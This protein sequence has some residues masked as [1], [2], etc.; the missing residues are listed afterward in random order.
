MTS[1]TTPSPG[2]NL[3]LDLLRLVAVLLVLGNHMTLAGSGGNPLLDA[4]SRVGWVGVD[5]FF[6]LSG[7][8]VS[9]LLFQEHLRTG[10]VAIGRFLVRRGLKIYPPFWVLIAY[11]VVTAWAH[12]LPQAWQAVASELFFVQNYGWHL[13][14]HTWSL[15]VEEHFYLLL[16]ALVWLLV[17]YRRDPFRLLP[18]ICGVALGAGLGLRILN[19]YQNP[20]YSYGAY[21]A[22][23]QLRIDSLFLGMLLSH[24]FY[25]RDLPARIRSFAPGWRIAFGATLLLVPAYFYN[26]ESHLWV[27]VIGYNLLDLGAALL[28]LGVVGL[29]SSR[30][31]ILCS[32][33]T[34][35]SAS[36]SIY[37]WHMP[38]EFWARRLWPVH[39]QGQ[40]HYF[41]YFV[42]FIGGSLLFGCV[43]S[44]LIEIPVL[45]LRDHWFP[46]RLAK[47]CTGNQP[48]Q[49]V[50]SLSPEPATVVP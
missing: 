34:M 30:S 39:A 18:A 19:A 9:G 7:F 20:E 17:R 38:M 11:S 45:K 32:L 41:G 15:A 27:S 35:G 36:Y 25:Y 43:M 6:V 42:T 3:G 26:R 1:T 31:R 4:W 49:T 46:S 48:S 40:L 8:L 44:R 47:D 28:V 16:S 22:P 33:A 13:W 14:A 5:L 50:L 2:R 24:L 10:H 21:L 37:L 29:A 12:G 23:T